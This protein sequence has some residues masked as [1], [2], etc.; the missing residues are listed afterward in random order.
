MSEKTESIL[1]QITEAYAKWKNIK[2]P[3]YVFTDADYK[4]LRKTVELVEAYNLNGEL[5]ISIVTEG[6]D[7]FKFHAPFLYSSVARAKL[8]AYTQN[9]GQINI[10][11][12]DEFNR[13]VTYL[14]SQIQSGLTVEQALMSD[15]IDMDAWFRIAITATV[16]P[17]VYNK[18]IAKARTEV[19]SNKEL[20]AFLLDK[21]LD[22]T[23]FK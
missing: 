23:R 9:F 7:Q 6:E 1:N 13:N 5:F 12:A 8:D 11:Y 16:I 14:R 10:T 3:Y 15:M 17:E 4:A 22:I 2:Y 19:K 18:Y 21:G 20:V